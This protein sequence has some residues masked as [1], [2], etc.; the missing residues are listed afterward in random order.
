MMLILIVM[1]PNTVLYKVAAT[2]FDC[3]GGTGPAYF[4]HVYTPASDISVFC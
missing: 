4:K 3:I 1:T 2:A